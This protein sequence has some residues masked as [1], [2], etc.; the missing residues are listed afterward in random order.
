MMRAFPF[1]LAGL[2]GLLGLLVASAAATAP[3]SPASAA[4]RPH[5][6]SARLVPGM[7]GDWSLPVALSCTGR[8]DCTAGGEYGPEEPYT[9]SLPFV[10]TEAGYR[11][12]PGSGSPVPAGRLPL[13]SQ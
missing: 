7:G 13:A 8:G 10:V 9:Q 5:W 11:Q 3:V 6:S 4:T 2:A 1:R 12:C